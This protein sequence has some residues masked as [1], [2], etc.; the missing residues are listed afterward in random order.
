MIL[1]LEHFPR[2]LYLVPAEVRKSGE[3]PEG[4]VLLKVSPRSGKPFFILAYYVTGFL[5]NV[6]SFT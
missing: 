5:I 4:T 3:D 6:S 1:L 2:S